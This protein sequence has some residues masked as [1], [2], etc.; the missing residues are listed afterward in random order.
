VKS[1][2]FNISKLRTL[3]NTEE[4]MKYRAIYTIF[5]LA[6]VVLYG[7]AT[8]PSVLWIEGKYK[9]TVDLYEKGEWKDKNRTNEDLFYLCYSYLKTKRYD[10]VNCP[11]E[12]AEMGGKDGN[13][14]AQAFLWTERA[15]MNIDLGH[16]EEALKDADKAIEASS[17]DWFGDA[18][19]ISLGARG[20]AHALLGNREKAIE[21]AKK[22]EKTERLV[23]SIIGGRYQAVAKSEAI[24][25]I[26]MALENYEDVIRVSEATE[27][28]GNPRAQIPN[29]FRVA[30]AYYETGNLYKAKSG[31]EDILSYPFIESFGAIY[32]VSLYNLGLI[33]L[34]ENKKEEGIS[35][36]KNAVV[37]IENQ[38]RTIATE[39]SKIGFV[40]D[41]QAV[42]Q[43]LVAALVDGGQYG[44]A[45]AYA[46]RGK[47]RALVDMLAAKKQFGSGEKAESTQLNAFLDELNKAE[48][49][50][51]VLDDNALPQQHT[52]TR[53]IVVQKKQEISQA[54]PEL[55]SLVTV[56]PPDVK[57]IQ[58]LL[59]PDETL[60][61]YFGSGN[62]FFAFIVNKSEVRG[63]K[64]D[65]D[66]LEIKIRSF[67]KGI[68]NQQSNAIKTDGQNL[69]TILIRPLEGM[70]ASENLTIVPHGALHYL[71]FSALYADGQ[72]LIEKY[73]LRV[74]P[75]AGVIKFLKVQREGHAGNMIAFGNPDLGNPQLDLPG[76]QK[77]V[78]AITKDM[79]NSLLLTRKKATET[80]LKELG[81]KYRY[82]HFAMHGTFD[83]EKPLF[84]GLMM[85][86]DSKNDGLLTVGELYDLYL[87]TN[88]VALSACETALGKVANGDDVVGFTRG[89]LYAGAS[90]IVSSL[91]QVDDQ[92][93]S[94]LMQ[95]FYKS[96][97]GTDKRRALRA[98]QLKVKDTYNAN[99]FFWAAFQITGAVQ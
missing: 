57:E 36:L 34:K 9:E 92:A 58:Q 85:A 95:E 44:E 1:F 93:T 79:P 64:L 66:G 24:S 45:F 86:R 82:V 5:F 76:A 61:E 68:M 60:V 55:A 43:D 50:A 12:Y 90:S 40:G 30:K 53:A 98:A 48:Q 88:L 6:I 28:Y 91:W 77:E 72:Y 15:T 62:T 39:A 23:G 69:Y 87:P 80:T 11:I 16:Y 75:S 21:I 83:A 4:K 33:K 97:K 46:E 29:N 63:V 38:R 10:K 67:R 52:T 35:M 70:F 22:I 37:E 20:L 59:P 78:I 17:G 54:D 14:R 96:L 47:A 94:I 32:W 8:D 89:F 56:T 71:P 25:K 19:H 31:F 7:C 49:N 18:V 65:A 73:N 51:I 99:P 81:S 26:Y 2:G 74:L 42:Y 27:G 41:K 84:S 13:K 3:Q